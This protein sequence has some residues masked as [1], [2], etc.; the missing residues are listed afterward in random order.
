MIVLV[1]LEIEL[2]IGYYLKRE[3]YCDD[4]TLSAV[5]RNAS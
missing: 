5:N 3:Y 1:C 2:A 4:H